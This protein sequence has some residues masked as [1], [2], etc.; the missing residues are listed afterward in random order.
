MVPEF[1]KK[2]KS[3][4]E[5][6]F[7]KILTSVFIILLVVLA[8]ANVRLYQ[9]KKDLAKQ[10]TIYSEE[11]KKIEEGNNKLKKEIANT[12]NIEY[13]E[14][15]AREENNMQKPGEKVVSFLLPKEKEVIKPEENKSWTAGVL[16]FWKGI[17]NIFK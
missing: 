15:V 11:I 14:K 8:V 4:D 12:E 3:G 13:I 17:L 10:L 7:I 16:N 1:H 5:G 6:L 2:Q 9:K